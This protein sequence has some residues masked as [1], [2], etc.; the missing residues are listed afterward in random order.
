[1]G[2]RKDKP[3]ERMGERLGK[4]GTGYQLLRVYKEKTILHG[5]GSIMTNK[6]AS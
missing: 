4:S 3:G 2:E 5:G 6:V 1:M